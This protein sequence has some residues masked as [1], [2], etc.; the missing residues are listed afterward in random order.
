MRGLYRDEG[1]S[2]LFEYCVKALHMS[3]GEASLRIRAARLS[4]RFPVVLAMVERGELHLSAL[5]ALAAV[6]TEDNHRELL[7]AA[8]HK[9]RRQVEQILADIFPGQS[10]CARFRPWSSD[11]AAFRTFPI[12]ERF[13]ERYGCP[14][15]TPERKQKI[16]SGNAIRLLSALPD[17]DP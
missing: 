14:A 6:L 15:L 16:L 13:Q 2:A 12:S 5:R 7:S 10:I 11:Q 1:Y 4:R 17:E 9:T 8:A 3:E